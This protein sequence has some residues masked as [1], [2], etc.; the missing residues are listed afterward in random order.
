MQFQESLLALAPAL[1]VILSVQFQTLLPVYHVM[2][3]VLLVKVG[4][5]RQTSKH[6][7]HVHQVI[8]FTGSRVQNA[9]LHS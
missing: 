6:V 3:A 9:T 1:Q 8:Q 4:V 2:L 5:V 7:F